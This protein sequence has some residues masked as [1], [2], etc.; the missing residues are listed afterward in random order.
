MASYQGVGDGVSGAN[1]PKRKATSHEA[2]LVTRLRM[3]E[4]KIHRPYSVIL[5]SARP[6]LVFFLT[7]A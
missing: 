6:I 4:T 7:A 1:S 5:N 3:C 2:D